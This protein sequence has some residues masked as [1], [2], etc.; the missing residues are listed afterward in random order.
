MIYSIFIKH[1]DLYN[2]A[3]DNTLTFHS[4]NFDEVVNVLQQESNISP[5]FQ[6][7]TANISCD[8]VVKLLGVDIDFMLNFDCHIKNIFKKAVQQL[9]I[10]KRKTCGMLITSPEFTSNFLFLFS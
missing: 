7:G 9:N 3:D 5:I 8:E 10:L 4:P 1:C 2:Y 6:I